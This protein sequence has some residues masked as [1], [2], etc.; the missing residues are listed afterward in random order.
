MSTGPASVAELESLHQCISALILRSCNLATANLDNY[1]LL[2]DSFGL[3]DKSPERWT[4]LTSF[5][6]TLNTA[7]DSLTAY[8]LVYAAR[9]GQGFH[10]VGESKYGS[11]AWDCVSLPAIFAASHS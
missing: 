3:V 7:S 9:H 1:D 8:K 4:N 10:N 2:D 11:A 6:E 5:V